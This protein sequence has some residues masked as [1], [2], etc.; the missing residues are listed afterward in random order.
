[1]DHGRQIYLSNNRKFLIKKIFEKQNQKNFPKK[2]KIL[3]KN[4][5]KQNLGKKIFEKKFLKFFFF[6]KKF[7]KDF[8]KFFFQLQLTI[9]SMSKK[10]LN[11]K[12]SGLDTTVQ[13]EPDFS[14]PCSFLE[15]LGIN[16]DCLHTKFYRNHQGRF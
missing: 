7:E 10:R 8:W 15:V 9:P 3:E 13:P 6:G 12:K 16:E 1:M 5:E 4:G 2:K 11:L 14:R